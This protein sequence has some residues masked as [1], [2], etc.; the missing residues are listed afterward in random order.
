MGVSGTFV[1]QKLIIPTLLADARLGTEV[2]RLLESTFGPLDY[3]TEPVP[4]GFTD[5]YQAEMGGEIV[6]LFY[7]VEELV[8]PAELAAIKRATNRIEEGLARPDGTRTVNLDPGLLSEGR[9]ILATTKDRAQRI[10]LRDGIYA[11]VTLLYRRGRYEPLPWTY[12]DYAGDAYSS[13]LNHVRSRYREQI[14]GR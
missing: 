10:P 3:R 4:F 6:R 14:H 2:S 9:L 12:P 7:T 8:D 1:P 5:Y 13:V 11:E